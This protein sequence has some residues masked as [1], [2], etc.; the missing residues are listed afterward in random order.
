VVDSL[1]LVKFGFFNCL[2]NATRFHQF[3]LIDIHRNTLI[4]HFNLHFKYL[5]STLGHKP[6][7]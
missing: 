7:H 5:K 4:K 2:T 6:L 3:G 1:G